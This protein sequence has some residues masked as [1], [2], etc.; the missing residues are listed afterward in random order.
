MTLGQKIRALRKEKKM[1]QS[2]LAGTEITRNML[3]RIESDDALPSL[4]T[5]L[6][7]S[8]RLRVPAGYFLSDNAS[9]LTYKKEEFLPSIKH[10]YSLGNYR[11]VIRLFRR[12]FDEADD[13][14]AFLVANSAVECAREALHHGALKTVGEYLSLA[15]EMKKKTIYAD[16]RLDALMTLLSATAENI[17]MPRFALTGSAY[18]ALA[19]DTVWEELY[20]Y[21]TEKTAGYTFLDPY[22]AAHAS[23]KALLTAGKYKDALAALTALEEQKSAPGFSVLVLFRLYG[24]IENCHKELY[25]YEAAYRYASKRLSLLAAFRG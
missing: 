8:E 4:P 24:D 9:L 3:S 12:D 16:A 25:N 19:A 11:E 17:Q 2:A 6:H 22:F 23:A 18:E 20:R 14:L 13:E 5:L 15:K 10:W 1:T 7:L 21:L